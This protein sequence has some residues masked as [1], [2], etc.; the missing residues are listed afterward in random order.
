MKEHPIYAGY[1]ISCDGKV[2][3]CLQRNGRNPATIDYSNP[4]E[5]KYHQDKDGYLCTS[6]QYLCKSKTVQVHRL[7][8]ETYVNKFS[9][10]LQVNHIYENK[11]NNKVSNLEWV[12][13]QKNSEHSKCKHLW[14]ILELETY[15]IFYVKNIN[16]FCRE[17][18]LNEANLRKTLNTK[19]QHKGYRAIY[20]E[21]LLQIAQLNMAKQPQVA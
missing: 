15:N 13:P 2:F 11:H 20:K 10:G 9:P 5:L 16:A 14:K 8:A 3:S 17:N 12:T 1:V 21:K 4:K 18:N 7:V 19:R 6:V